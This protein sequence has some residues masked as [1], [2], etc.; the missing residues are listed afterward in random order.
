M[1]LTR[2]WLVRRV[3]VLARFNIP[4]PVVGGL[5]LSLL[6]L[7]FS[8][9]GWL[10]AKFATQVGARFWV[11]LVTPETLLDQ[12]KLVDVNR[13][14]LMAFFT[15]IWLNASWSLVKRGSVQV[16]VFLL[17]ATALAVFQNLIGIGLTKLLGVS[18]VL[19]VVCGSVTKTGGHGAAIGFADVLEKAGLANAKVLGVAAATFGLVMG[20]LLGGPIGGRLMRRFNLKTSA[21]RDTHLEA[22]SSGDSGILT[23]LGALSGFG[24]PLLTHGLLLLACVKF[25]AWVSYFIQKTGATLPRSAGWWPAASQKLRPGGC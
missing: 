14:F 12:T 23:D 10:E 8:A 3:R 24:P 5:L 18:P 11:W 6:I 13:P 20:G 7:A 16:L 1:L 19:G 17:L 9:A 22:G 2:E 4:A 15:C 21:A 25:G